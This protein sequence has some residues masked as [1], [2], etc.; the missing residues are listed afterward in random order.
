MESQRLLSCWIF[1]EGSKLDDVKFKM[2]H[3]S[4][5]LLDVY[6]SMC[7]GGVCLHQCAGEV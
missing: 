3:L 5:Y 2:L 1:L 4:D 7:M 6:V